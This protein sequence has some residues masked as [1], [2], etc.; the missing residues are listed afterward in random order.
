[1]LETIK[2]S[3]L[4]DLM[5]Q[6][7][8][9]TKKPYIKMNLPKAKSEID[10][11]IELNSILNKNIP[12]KSLIGMGYNSTITPKV[13][14]RHILEN[15]K[16]YT[17]YTPYQPEISQGRLEAQYNF[18]EVMKELTG[19]PISNSSL[20]D[21][22]STAAE[23]LNMCVKKDKNKFLVDS[24]MHPQI[25]EVLHTKATVSNIKLIITNFN[26]DFFNNLNPDEF[27][28]LMFS[29]PNTYGNINI[30]YNLLNH[31]DR[32]H[33]T[34]TCN[35]DI[36]SLFKLK[37][38]VEF[39]IDICFG[40]SQRLGIPMYYGGP[41]PAYLV[42]DK[43]F[44]RLMPG[45]IIGK[46]IDYSGKECFRLGL[47]TREQHI[48]KEKATSN[49]C[50]SQSLLANIVGLYCY[51]NGKEGIVDIANE[52]NKKTVLLDILLGKIGIINK[53][54]NYFDTLYIE[55]INANK[56]YELLKKNKYIVR[57]LDNNQICITVSESITL[58]DIYEICNI[59]YSIYDKILLKDDFN[60]IYNSI[61]S[62]IN[63]ELVRDNNFLEC[64]KFKYGK[65][66]TEFLR[67]NQY[68]IDKDYTLCDGMI[69]L[70]SCT[71][72]LNSVYQLEPL[73]WSNTQD[74]HPYTEKEFVLGYH[75]LFDKIGNYLKKIT[76]F[77]HVSFQSNSGAMGEYSGLLCIRK[78]H[79]ENNDDRYIC[80]IP[81]S[82]HGTNFSSASLV[83][84]KV[85]S[86]SDN[87]NIEDFTK[88]VEGYKN[89]LA[90]LMIT[91]PGTNGIFQ[92]NIKEICDIIHING[93]LVYMDGANMNAQ[94]GFV[95]PFESN[96]DVCHLNLH[97]TFCIPHGGGGPGM[98]PILCND[99][100][101]PFLPSNINQFDKMPDK[102]IGM[103]TSSNWSS[104][105]LLTIPY[106]YIL[107]MGEEGLREATQTAIL[108]ANYLKCKLEDYYTIIDVNENNRV[109]HEFIID[110]S[111]FREKGISELDIAKR[112]IDYS[113]HP[114]TMSWPRQN[115]LM[116]EPTESENLDELDRL[117]DSLIQ[118]RKEIDIYE[119]KEDNILKNAPHS[120]DLIQNWNYDYS[121]N[122]AFFPLPHLKDKKFWP[123]VG[124]VN[125][126]IGDK[127]LLSKK[128]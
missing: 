70:G 101:A 102:S 36:L 57:K 94:V 40:T 112:L 77:K 67:Y 26:N 37:P 66:E 115:V 30:P 51:Y 29:Y 35:A 39:G 21:E 74:Y 86:Y 80:L 91:Y 8:N 90:A 3:N 14:Q 18:Q 96:A 113:F 98:G 99:K 76:G 28:G 5:H 12:H 81:K 15:P 87:I 55:S 22:S 85:I 19:L 34:K 104:A 105:S 2:V 44:I 61:N 13:L 92:S 48:K 120:I 17:A 33:I 118:I 23:V 78:Y 97:K 73:S 108:N 82:A 24:S 122:E 16:W 10:S 7:I 111:E 121:M 1:M 72:K 38:P 109:A 117:V 31:F 128:N 64:E 126:V 103:I 100:L 110:T 47:Q 88:L 89:N 52:I 41:H 20:L 93:G 79:L 43:K 62:K 95:N 54:E 107:G 53:N 75:N 116:F 50:T 127:Q 106:L 49:I 68:L 42:A 25:L 125:D 56:I 114:P 119:N 123:S 32:P 71:M 83:G 59:I 58:D 63:S 11:S 69:P 124:R 45:R 27:C 9:L 46:T 60:M 4:S 6:S 84:F 65:T